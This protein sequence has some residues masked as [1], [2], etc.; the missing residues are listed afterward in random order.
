M[1]SLEDIRKNDNVIITFLS[2]DEKKITLD[3]KYIRLHCDGIS[4]LIIGDE[5]EPISDKE[6]IPLPI[7]YDILILFR[8]T[9]YALEFLERVE[10]DSKRT[11]GEFMEVLVL[12]PILNKN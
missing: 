2:K 11:M 4:G 12:I 8:Y 9:Y 6:A 3:L 1:A 7:N 5:D 10:P